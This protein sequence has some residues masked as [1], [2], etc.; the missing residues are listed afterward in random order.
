[1][2]CCSHQ[3][4]I[5]AVWSLEWEGDTPKCDFLRRAPI[6]S[7]SQVDLWDGIEGLVPRALDLEDT[8]RVFW[9]H[10]H[11]EWESPLLWSNHPLLS[12]NVFWDRKRPLITAYKATRYFQWG[13]TRVRQE[14]VESCPW[15]PSGS[16]SFHSC[17]SLGI[18]NLGENQYIFNSQI[19]F[20]WPVMEEDGKKGRWMDLKNEI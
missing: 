6:A 2:H 15:N 5:P 9:S 12:D 20:L 11:P 3:A 13:E 7:E 10:L 18:L 4:S 19:Y 17:D 8:F 14:E 16:L 1:M